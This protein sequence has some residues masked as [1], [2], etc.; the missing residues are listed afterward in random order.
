MQAIMPPSFSVNHFE[1]VWTQKKWAARLGEELSSLSLVKGEKKECT[2]SHVFVNIAG[3]SLFMS[4]PAR[5]IFLWV[6]FPFQ[7]ALLLSS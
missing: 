4:L 2:F 5:I 6:L 3:G 7:I 1:K